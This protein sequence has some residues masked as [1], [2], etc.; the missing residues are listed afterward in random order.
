M[1]RGVGEGQRERERERERIPS[2]LCTVNADTKVG[3]NPRNHEI[4]T[5]AEI[6][7]QTLN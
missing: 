6:K 3:L 7:N 1:S 4:M 2:R 5:S